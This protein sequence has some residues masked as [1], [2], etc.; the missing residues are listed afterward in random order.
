M[1]TEGNDLA[2]INLGLPCLVTAL[3]SMHKDGDTHEIANV[4]SNW[5]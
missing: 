2:D 4:G 5:T 1:K 3:E